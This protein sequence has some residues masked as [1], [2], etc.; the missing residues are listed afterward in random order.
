MTPELEAMARA[1]AGSFARDSEPD[2]QADYV[3]RYWRKWV[4][5]ARAAVRALPIQYATTIE[6]ILGEGAL[7]PENQQTIPQT[8]GGK[9]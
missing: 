6:A 1:L 3:E 5:D 7:L 2:R 4:E 9:P 8:R